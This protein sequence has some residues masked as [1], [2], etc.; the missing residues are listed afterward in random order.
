MGY[1]ALIILLA[2]AMALPVS[3]QTAGEIAGI[4]TDSTGAVIQ[5]AAVTVTNQRTNAVR[6]TS[7]N[8][9]GI[10]SFPGLVPG[11]YEVKVE[12]QGFRTVIRRDIQLEVQQVARVNAAL[13]VGEVTQAIEV[14]GGS[15]LLTTDSA[16]TG[17]VIEQERIVE[18]PLN[19]RNFLQL[20]SLSPNVT[21]GFNMP[22]QVAGRQGGTRGDQ[23]ISISGMRG[24]WNH[25]TLDG[26]ENTDVNFNL[27]ILLPSVDALQE[28]K[29]Q[30]GVYPAEFGRAAS[31]I[32]VSTR[33]GSNQFHGALYEFLRND[34]L[35][36]RQ[37]DFIGTRPARAPFKWNQYGFT[38]GGP[39]WIP[40]VFNGTNRLFFMTNF[41]GF[42]DRKTSYGIYTTPTVAMRNGDFTHKTGGLIDPATRKVVN[43]AVVSEVFPGNRIPASRF[44]PVSLKLLE[45]WPEPNVNTAILRDNFQQT[46]PRKIDKDQF[47]VRIDFN[48]SS[49][50]Q[51]F[52]RYSWTDEATFSTGMKLNGTRLSTNA[53]QTMISNTRVLSP[54]KVNEFRMGWNQFMNQI[55]REL[56]GVRNVVDEL[57]IPG[58]KAPDEASWGIPRITALVGVSGFGDESSGPFTVD[59][60]I[61]Q[62]SDTFSWIRGKHSLRFGGEFRYDQYPQGGNE[63]ARGSF[64][65]NG[66]YST[67]S[68]ADLL[69]GVLSKAESSIALASADFVANNASLFIDDTYRVTPKLTLNLGLRWEL[70]QPFYDKSENQVNIVAPLLADIPHV[71]DINLHPVLVRT[72]SGDFYEGKEFRYPGIQVARDGRFGKRLMQTDYNNFA[73]RLGVAYSPSENW[74]VRTGFGVFYSAES[75]NS[76]FDMNRGLG[77]RVSRQ[78][79]PQVPDIT[80]G[81]FLTAATRPWVLPPMPFLWGVKPNVLTTYTMQY[82]FDIQ[83]KLSPNMSLEIGYSG[84]QHRKLQALQN[85][86]AP[87]PGTT[88]YATRAPFPEYGVLQVVHSE[89]T[90]NYNGLGFK[91][92]RRMSAGLTALVSYT[93]SKSLDSASAIRGNYDDIFP[94]DSRCLGCD[95]GYSAFNTPHRFV[96]STLWEL[97]FGKGK[98][99]ADVGGVLNHIVGGW[100]IGSIVTI[101]NGR[102]LNM[103]AGYD[104][105]GT[106][107]YGNWRLNATG[108]DAYLPAGQRSSNQ[109]FNTN[110]FSPPPVGTFGNV[111]RNRL[112]GPT[113]FQWDFSTHKEFQIRES[114]R[115]QFRFEA[116]NFPNHPSLGNPNV[117]WGSRTSTP[118]PAFGTIRGTAYSMREL[119]FGLKYIF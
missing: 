3:A 14:T 76:R 100:Q 86:N 92:T 37:Y 49:S 2:L 104:A 62:V 85:T 44:D 29:V 47:T 64:E 5:N 78:A 13:E 93:W 12:M 101:Q 36:A 115:L 39:V 90:G 52:G 84:S 74:T 70:F 118:N 80:F 1:K 79:N 99:L 18:L 108:Q 30:T 48:E 40:K 97:P 107:T 42:R 24:T 46:Q 9:A 16:T 63:F 67:D 114:H 33:P 71:P 27:Y 73:P 89:G 81:N 26:L 10:Y 15:V 50:S 95:Y 25:Y 38:L 22:G 91:L 111:S 69:L 75:G 19:G 35:D 87:L 59:D 23:N 60:G 112:M 98:P 68:T 31:Q 28:F 43:G 54:T 21:Y 7:S 66:Q 96:T 117:T 58:L 55:G 113:T 4:V 106:A 116:F 41:E 109:W 82:L 56:A 61:L 57:G 119:Q 102:P 103:A 6:T 105:P 45:F 88:S 83:R 32:N 17:T 11:I 94:Q 110:A 51:W 20:V 72:G 77:G 53:W 34:K 8:D 65:F